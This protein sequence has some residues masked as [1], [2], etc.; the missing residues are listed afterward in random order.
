MAKMSS[1]FALFSILLIYFDRFKHKKVVENFEAYFS[2]HSKHTRKMS[3]PLG[4]HFDTYKS[5]HF[6]PFKTTLNNDQISAIGR[7]FLPKKNIFLTKLK[8]MSN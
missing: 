6:I 2:S 3:H 5:L 8:A 1:F 4:V 7:F